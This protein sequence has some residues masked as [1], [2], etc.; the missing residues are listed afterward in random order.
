MS[1]EHHYLIYV[2]YL[3]FRYSGW[4]KQPRQK[5]VE[6]MIIKTLNFILPERDFKILGAGRTDAKV[7]ALQAA[8]KLYLKGDPVMNKSRFVEDLNKN[9]PADIK[10]VK[11]VDLDKKFNIISDC[12][13]KEYLYFFSCGSKNHPFSAPFITGIIDDLDIELMKA[14]AKLFEGKHNYRAYTTQDKPGRNFNR[15][16]L[17]AKIERNQ[18]LRAN[19]FPDTSYI[20]SIRARGFLRYQVRM[21]MGALFQLG[22]HEKE[23]EDIRKSLRPDYDGVL[24]EI[25]PG[26]GLVLNTLVFKTEA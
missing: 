22:K 18:L 3:G 1:S 4:Q 21:I 20:F 6:A 19:F 9:L 17:Q 24:S 13:E 14:G 26:S 15:E 5:T 11:L 7:S 8:F 25:A 12:E 23:L 16:V 2:Q 10:I